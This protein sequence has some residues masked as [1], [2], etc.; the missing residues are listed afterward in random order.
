MKKRAQDGCPCGPNRIVVLYA[1]L[2]RDSLPC[3]RCGERLPVDS[4]KLP[5]D[6]QQQLR[7]FV[8]QRHAI[9]SLWF[10]SAQYEEWAKGELDGSRSPINRLARDL[11]SKMSKHLETYA[12]FKPH[13]QAEQYVDP[14]LDPCPACGG[15]TEPSG[16]GEPYGRRCPACRILGAGE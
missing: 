15:I 12:Y 11:A 16:F 7:A 6:L 10:S 5:G 9:E 1:S 14:F 2:D 4:I 3:A 8:D 13:A